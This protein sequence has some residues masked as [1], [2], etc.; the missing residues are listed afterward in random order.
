V[1]ENNRKAVELL[2]GA[3]AHGRPVVPGLG[4]RVQGGLQQQGQIDL[5][6]GA[7]TP[8][9]AWDRC[10]LGHVTSPVARIGETS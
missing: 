6:A 7:W 5:L 2:E 8:P 10:G 9:S 4:E 1:N 3:L